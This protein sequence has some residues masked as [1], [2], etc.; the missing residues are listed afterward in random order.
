MALDKLK[1]QTYT[2]LIFS[3]L[4]ICWSVW[5]KTLLP[6]LTAASGFSVWISILG[7]AVIW[8]VPLFLLQRNRGSQLVSIRQMLT[9]P[10]PWFACVVMLCASVAFLFTVRI[11][12]GKNNTY[13]LW[14][15][16]FFLF[17]ISAG[18]IEEFCFRGVLFNKQA[19]DIGYIPATLLN[20]GMFMLFHY[21]LFAE[22]WLY[23]LLSLRSL[24]LFAMGFLFS[25]SFSRW[26]NIWLLIV[27][28]SVWNVLSYFFALAG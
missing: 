17:S 13:I 28:H 8:L 10:F 1:S 11:A 19:A 7:K 5:Q 20:G 18:F 15:N 14:D 26:K 22:N 24:L 12:T 23:Q 3:G 16:T 4:Y 9:T 21:P 6:T 27:V 25:M 2:L